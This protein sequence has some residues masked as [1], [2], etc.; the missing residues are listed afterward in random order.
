MIKSI[1]KIIIILFLM[2]SYT[3]FGQKASI[4]GSVVD[5]LTKDFLIGANVYIVGTSLG[6]STNNEGSFI[7]KNINTGSYKL[8]ISYI[9]YESR[10]IAIDLQEPINYDKG[11]ISLNYTTI[12]GESVEVTAQAKG[13]MDAINKQLKAKSIKNIVSSDRI[14]EL[15]DA[16]AAETVA[17][18][19]GVS[20]RREG[21]EG[22]KVVIR[23]LSP[24]YNKITV[25]GANLSSTDPDDRSTD[26]S[27]IS[28]YM[29]DGIEVTKAG[30]PDQEADV[31]GGTV[32]FKLRKA[33]PGLH[34]NA[35]TQ[36]MYNGLRKTGGDYKFV[37]DLSNRYFNDR[38][39]ILAQLDLENRDRS[40][41]N[42]GAGY[43]NSGAELD[44]VN[45]LSLM[46]LNLSDVNRVND[47]E[48]SLF[49]IDINIPNGNISYSGLNSTIEKDE[50][51]RSDIYGLSSLTRSYHTNQ[52]D[53]RI[54]VISETWKYEQNI[55][56]NLRL[57]LYKS[58]SASKNENRNILF[59]AQKIRP[60]GSLLESSS[61]ELDS[62]V[63]VNVRN[64]GI[65]TVQ[66]YILP[67]D[68]GDPDEKAYYDRYD[69]NS[70]ITDEKENSLG[71]D[72]KYDFKL[73]NQ[74]SGA[75]KI[76]S[77]S[78]VKKRR[79]DKNYEYSYFG[80]VAIQDKR[81]TIIQSIPWLAENVGLGTINPSYGV[82]MDD[83][84]T[85]DLFNGKYN[86]G[87][88]FDLD[89]MNELY[90]F[91]RSDP[92]FTNATYHEEIMHHKHKTTSKIYDYSGREDYVGNYFMLDL[93]IGQKLNIITGLRSEQIETQ[94]NSY[95][96]L[97]NSLAH[98]TTAGADSAVSNSRT[99]AY[100]LPALFLKYNPYE[101]LSLR[102]ANTSTLTR[103]NYT[104]ILP[105]YNIN[106]QNYLV[107]YSNPSLKPGESNNKD[108]VVSINNKKLGMLSFSYF[109]K[110]I[111]DLI[112]SGGRR[113]IKQGTADSLYGLPDY[114]DKYQIIEYKTNNPF[115]VYLNGFE[116]DYQTRFW[117]LPGMLKGLVLN[118]NYTKT[119]SEVKYPRTTIAYDFT[120]F[121]LSFVNT[122][123]FYVD[124]LIDQPEDI[125]NL[126]LGY[127]Y[128]GFSG[129]L[130][131]LYMGDVFI[132][133]NFWPEMRQTTDSYR[134]YDLSMKQKLPVNGL[135][136]YLNISNLAEAIDINRLN[137]FNPNESDF[138]DSVLEDIT[139]SNKN[140]EDKLDMLPRSSR[141]KSL[142][143]HYGRTIDIGFRFS[144]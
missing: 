23:G 116:I 87:P 60:Y 74:I 13:Q 62:V 120:T 131:M 54:N 19:P 114:A 100:S 130:S 84:G 28:Q 11:L 81:D 139:S 2:S 67:W 82:F 127:D 39:G 101:W 68:S 66:K 61:G 92:Y 115:P 134:R 108:Y 40:S 22:N 143:Q 71:L 136:L 29:L 9:G 17:R 73:S 37:L 96:G 36:G 48:N 83:Q 77:K 123:S 128:K 38:L 117:Y 140:I 94:Y 105:F 95:Q 65:E 20:I 125:I 112:F 24:K 42:L 85:L 12:D 80:Y 79:Y 5:S 132:S 109:T 47:R 135:E 53:S 89:K 41:Q 141:A 142:E 70:F 122:D 72:I 91:L 46:S 18:I 121:P 35:V 57:E 78:K 98:F 104:D 88:F 107:E 43:F 69:A 118:A 58:Y 16:N 102:Y 138:D 32:N 6:S 106:G 133:T 50:I 33:K 26:L 76:G 126:S 90:N 124:R 27:M 111:E 8:K 21:G 10:E 7:L 15:P 110:K 99:N 75:L 55:F 14:Q 3:L 129:R 119:R 93:N 59:Q 64:K 51:N 52:L 137:G 103:P 97:A 25:N 30:T 113:F 31:L 63:S 86:I 1:Y 56:P 45:S 4:T 49:V 144:F 34:G 44:S